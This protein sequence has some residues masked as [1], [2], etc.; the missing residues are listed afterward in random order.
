MCAHY[1]MKKYCMLLLAAVLALAVSCISEK[2]VTYDDHCYISEVSLGTLKR[3]IH[4]LDSVGNDTILIRTY[5]GGKNFPMTIN[6]RTQFIENR[7][8]LLYGTLLRSV[9]LNVTYTGSTLLYR[10]KGD[11]DSTW[12]QYS[13]QDSM[14]LRKDVEL[15]AMANDGLSSRS[16]TLRLNVHKQEGDSLYWNQ[17]DAAVPMLRVMTQ[18]CAIMV[19]DRLSVLG[20]EDGAVKLAERSAEGEWSSTI[21]NLPAEAVVETVIKKGGTFFVGTTNGDIY[22]SNDAKAWQK[23]NTQQQA[24]RILAG[25]S[26]ESLYALMDGELYRGVEN[27]VGEW[28]FKAE[29][30]DESTAF[31]PAAQVKTLLIKQA[32]GNNRLVMVGNRTDAADVT[33]VV[34]NKM[35]NADIKEAEAEWML[36]NQTAD[37]KYTL[38][39]LEYLNLLQYDGKCMAFGGPSVP[40]KGENKA[41][42]ALYVSEDY[43]ITW[44]KNLNMMKLP[45]QLNGVNGPIMSVVDDNNVIWIIANGEVWR[46]R[47]NR[48]GFERQ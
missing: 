29:S 42:D 3:E 1:K 13:S 40:G 21:T 32:N 2:E 28:V 9:L 12:L 23:L 4:S 48:L 45:K 27:E 37:N 33:S 30:L 39:Q 16:Y 24:G 44:H 46:G 26:S 15:L 19:Q 17:V 41:M 18:P 11:V 10:V 34:W 8:S 7:D 38:P 14:D 35:W 47:L 5:T 43:G 31:L 22:A 6:Q 20:K 36:L 25:A